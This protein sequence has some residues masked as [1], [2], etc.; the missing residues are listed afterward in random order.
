M[1]AEQMLVPWCKPQKRW[2]LQYWV[3]Q[4][5]WKHEADLT[6]LTKKGLSWYL[7]H[8]KIKE[9]PWKCPNY[10]FMFKSPREL[11]Q[12]GPVPVIRTNYLCKVERTGCFTNKFPRVTSKQKESNGAR[13][14]YESQIFYNS[15]FQKVCHLHFSRQPDSMSNWCDS[16]M[17]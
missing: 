17:G 8:L 5:H 13:L 4:G 2:K 12:T 3:L 6:A 14:K 1:Q 16:F 10:S 7:Q 15:L 11:E 9:I